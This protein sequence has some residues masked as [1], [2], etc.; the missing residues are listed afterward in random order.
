MD[1]IITLP[2]ER[3]EKVE[4]QI[5][6]ILAKYAQKYTDSG[7]LSKA[8]LFTLLQKAKFICLFRNSPRHKGEKLVLGSASIINDRLRAF[9]D[10]DFLIEICSQ[11]WASLDEIGRE[12]LIFHELCHCSIK[13]KD[14]KQT[15]GTKFVLG[16]L[17]H[18]FEGFCDEYSFFG[19]WA[20]DLP[21]ELNN[22]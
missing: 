1:D 11:S 3:S 22:N 21:F 2:Y 6:E 9:V 4:K 13:E 19:N 12:A 15:G 7:L 17:P 8:E 18:E 16:T 10:G 5:Y 20:G 14:D